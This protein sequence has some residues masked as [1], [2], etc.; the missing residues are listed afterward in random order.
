MKYIL[1]TDLFPLLEHYIINSF[2]L[3]KAEAV[4]CQSF[5]FSP[6]LQ[7]K[8]DVHFRK[9]AEQETLTRDHTRVG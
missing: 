5:L 6:F 8:P 1:R 9:V 3:R 2:L 7:I 4:I